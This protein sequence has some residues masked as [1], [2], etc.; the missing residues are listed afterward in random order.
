MNSKKALA[1]PAWL[2]ALIA[3]LI[4]SSAAC[5]FSITEDDAKII[6]KGV[7]QGQTKFY[8]KTPDNQTKTVTNISVSSGTA[9]LD[10]STGQWNVVLHVEGKDEDDVTRGND[11]LVLVSKKGEVLGV[12]SGAVSK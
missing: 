6:A 3:L 4:V 8:A 1:L 12:G 7:I 9:F 10:P 5:T 2:A 11:V